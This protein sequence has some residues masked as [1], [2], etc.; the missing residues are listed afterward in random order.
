MSL[1]LPNDK[2]HIVGAGNV[3]VWIGYHSDIKGHAKETF[4]HIFNV[5]VDSVSEWYKKIKDKE[6]VTIVS[7]PQLTPPS[8][9]QKPDYVST[10]LDM[11]GN[12]WQFRGGE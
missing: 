7:E 5:Y 1:D 4:R 12:C 6:G 10:W 8:T 11:E 9:P 3:Q 2:G